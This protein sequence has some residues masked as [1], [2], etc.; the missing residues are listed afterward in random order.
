MLNDIEIILRKLLMGNFVISFEIW[1][2]LIL[3]L[4]AF[5]IIFFSCICQ[6]LSL[7][8]KIALEFVLQYLNESEKRQMK[9][10][11]FVD[12]LNQFEKRKVDFRYKF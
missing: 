4:Y 9:T 2:N 1:G 6:F 5:A 8:K 3:S 7:F 11:N 12:V 10:L